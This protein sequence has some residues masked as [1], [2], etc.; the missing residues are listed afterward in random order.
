MDS[1]GRFRIVCAAG[2]MNVMVAR[3]RQQAFEV[4]SFLVP[5]PNKVVLVATKIDADASARRVSY[6]EG[7]SLAASLRM[8]AKWVVKELNLSSSASL[9]FRQRLYRP[10]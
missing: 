2:R 7:V 1:F 6:E 4:T 3:N 8:T 9:V 5:G 10:P